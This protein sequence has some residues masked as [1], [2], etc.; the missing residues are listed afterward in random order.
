MDRYHL[1]TAKF[2]EPTMDNRLDIIEA[3]INKYS[4]DLNDLKIK[5]SAIETGLINI[6]ESITDLKDSISILEDWVYDNGVE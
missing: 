5:F 2:M 3:Q 4:E 6:K 1:I